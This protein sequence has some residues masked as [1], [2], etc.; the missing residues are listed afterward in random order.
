MGV[1]Y[2]PIW[3][4]V[5]TVGPSNGLTAIGKGVNWYLDGAK[6][7]IA[8]TWPTKPFPFF[9]KKGAVVEVTPDPAIVGAPVPCT[10]CPSAGGPGS[11]SVRA[12][13]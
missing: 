3:Y 7:Y 10:G 9:Q 6:R 8:G 1:D 4:D 5:T 2:G 12:S 11:P 13:H